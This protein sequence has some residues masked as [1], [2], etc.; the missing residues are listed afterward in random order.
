[1]GEGTELSCCRD[2]ASS[3]SFKAGSGR[4]L[5]CPESGLTWPV[6][7]CSSLVSCGNAIAVMVFLLATSLPQ[8]VES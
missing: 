5:H 1:M 6:V 4:W 8:L 3:V 2:P 7:S